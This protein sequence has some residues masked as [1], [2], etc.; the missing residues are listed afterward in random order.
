MGCKNST[1][2]VCDSEILTCYEDHSSCDCLCTCLH[3]CTRPLEFDISEAIVHSGLNRLIGGDPSGAKVKLKF[4]DIHSE[5]KQRHNNIHIWLLLLLVLSIT[6]FALIPLVVR[7]VGRFDEVRC[8]STNICDAPNATGGEWECP[9]NSNWTFDCCYVYCH[10]SRK[11][12]DDFEP[13][14]HP[15]TNFNE[16]IKQNKSFRAECNCIENPKV[17]AYNKK[18]GE[19]KLYGDFDEKRDPIVLRYIQI[20]AG[21]VFMVMLC[22]TYLYRWYYFQQIK[23]ILQNHF[24]DWHIYGIKEEYRHRQKHRRGVLIF[25]LPSIQATEFSSHYQPN[26]VDSND[27]INYNFSYNRY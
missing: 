15:V 13:G 5:I 4:S 16:D 18:C 17:K 20:I 26:Q 24:Q 2:S 9:S 23:K 21:F 12:N 3:T 14:C 6:A 1:P 27:D 25:N 22:A 11:S 8:S 10:E 19:V 7:K